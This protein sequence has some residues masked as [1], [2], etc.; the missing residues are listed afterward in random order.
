[1]GSGVNICALLAG[2]AAFAFAMD[3]L[4]ERNPHFHTPI[5]IH[6]PPVGS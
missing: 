6:S 3:Q 5:P 1:M 2:L 4:L